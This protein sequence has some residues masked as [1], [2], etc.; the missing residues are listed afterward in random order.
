M[1]ILIIGENVGDFFEEFILN[2]VNSV[3]DFTGF[4]RD[5]VKNYRKS[6]KYK[7]GEYHKYIV[8]S[9]TLFEKLFFLEKIILLSRRN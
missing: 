5:G 6:V 7:H 1:K 3:V 8:L 2:F 4:E 9:G